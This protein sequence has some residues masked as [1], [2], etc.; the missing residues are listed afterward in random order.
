MRHLEHNECPRIR[1]ADVDQIRAQKLTFSHELEKRSGSQFGDYF[2]V[3]HPSVQSAFE[4]QSNL[5][6]MSTV[7]AQS[8]FE[9]K[10]YMAHPSFFKPN[11]FPNVKEVTESL[12]SIQQSDNGKEKVDDVNNPS[13]RLFDPRKYYNTLT[14][15]YKCPQ[16]SCKFVA[17]SISAWQDTDSRT[18]RL[19][20]AAA[21]S[22]P[23]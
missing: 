9:D 23:T 22:S 4:A 15:K 5:D 21:P 8:E 10:A 3:S 11:D 7:D 14:H 18:G 19:F 16:P 6:A 12:D 20:P 2:P 1:R 17:P 13:H